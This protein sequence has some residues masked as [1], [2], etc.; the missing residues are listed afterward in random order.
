MKVDYK[1]SVVG[2]AFMH[3]IVSFM[4][5]GFELKSAHMLMLSKMFFR[6]IKYYNATCSQSTS[7]LTMGCKRKEVTNKIETTN[8]ENNA[9]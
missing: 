6:K 5:I 4:K 2:V 1:K 7:T 3:I 8:Q 9:W